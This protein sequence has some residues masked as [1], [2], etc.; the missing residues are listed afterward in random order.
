MSKERR[1]VSI[2]PEVDDYLGQ[3]GTCASTLVNKLVKQH[4]S[5]GASEEQ[6]LRFR[7]KQ[8]KSQESELESR[9]ENKRNERRELEQ[10][11]KQY[12]GFKEEII[13]DAE[14]ALNPRM[15]QADNDAVK[16]WAQKADMSVA[17]FIDEME[18]RLN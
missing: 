13:A 16:N 9:L 2:D 1:T 8:V 3:E 18:S 4:M 7:L 11:L 15:L 6:I 10:R 14:D 5:G 12:T 17:D